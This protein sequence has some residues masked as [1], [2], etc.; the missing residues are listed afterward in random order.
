MGRV[1]G[2]GRCGLTS[3]RLTLGLPPHLYTT[4]VP[5]TQDLASESDSYAG[6]EDYSASPRHDIH[7]ENSLLNDY[8]S[9]LPQRR[10][11]KR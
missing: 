3:T 11:L 5:H 7:P 2:G 8:E 4:L 9:E 10:D 1:G 6:T